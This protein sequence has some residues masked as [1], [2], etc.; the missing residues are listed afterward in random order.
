MVFP[1]WESVLAVGSALVG[2]RHS[3]CP[4][5]P[6]RV[7]PFSLTAVCLPNQFRC[8][9]GQCVLIKQQCDSFPDCADGSDE[10]MCGE[11]FQAGPPMGGGPEAP[12]KFHLVGVLVSVAVMKCSDKSNLGRTGL[13]DFQFRLQSAIVGW[14]REGLS[15]SVPVCHC[16]EVKGR[17][18]SFTLQSAIV[19]R[20]REGRSVPVTVCFCGEVKGKT[21]S[22]GYS[23]PLWGDQRR[24]SKQLVIVK[25]RE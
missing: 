16:G 13:L 10:L 18:F 21:F 24:G 3:S 15:V 20:S 11:C 6:L 2:T 5:A 12:G 19:G 1:S 14:S 17:T 4:P 8:T 25:K 22:S 9:S 23:L 7:T